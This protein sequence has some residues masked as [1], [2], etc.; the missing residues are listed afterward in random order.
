[1]STGRHR[2][3]DTGSTSAGR[4][5]DEQRAAS[6]EE[7]PAQSVLN[8]KVART[9]DVGTTLE[10]LQRVEGF[11]A[12]EPLF[13]GETQADLSTIYVAHVDTDRLAEAVPKIEA[14]D[15]VEYV[16]KPASRK[17]IK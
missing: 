12:I 17:L 13:P 3:K 1:M 16:E 5:T 10:R 8:I 7:S 14:D 15:D 4:S 2:T 6:P 11:R 9:A